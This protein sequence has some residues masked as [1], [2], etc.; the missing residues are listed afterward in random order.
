MAECWSSPFL[1]CY[2]RDEG[3]VHKSPIKKGTRLISSHLDRTSWVNKGFII[4][5]LI[6]FYKLAG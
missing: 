4:V 5:S 6:D 2:G 3:E 1:H